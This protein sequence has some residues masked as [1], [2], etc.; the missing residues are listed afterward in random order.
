VMVVAVCGQSN[1]T[2]LL[3]FVRESRRSPAD[4][5]KPAGGPSLFFLWSARSDR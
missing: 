4:A 2:T 3:S 1:G 5:L